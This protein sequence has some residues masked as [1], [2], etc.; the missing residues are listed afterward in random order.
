MIMFTIFFL[1][2]DDNNRVWS[3]ELRRT[4]IMCSDKL[5][6]DTLLNIQLPGPPRP[7]VYILIL[8]DLVTSYQL[9]NN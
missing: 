9:I 7:N 3:F 5:T 2:F 8:Y 4:N 1:V 6:I